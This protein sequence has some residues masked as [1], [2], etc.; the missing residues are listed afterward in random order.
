MQTSIDDVIS[1]VDV[2]HLARDEL[3]AVECEKRGRGPNI[4]DTDQ[5]AGGR[6][7]LRLVQQLV[8]FRNA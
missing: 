5:A 1:A 4:I 6:L 8:E 3:C 2:H 7:A